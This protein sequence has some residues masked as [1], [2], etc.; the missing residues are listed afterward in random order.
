[1]KL[2]LNGALTIGTLDGANIEIRD[3]VGADN[4]FLF[5]LTAEEVHERQRCGA[6]SRSCVANDP[7]LQEALQMINEG[8]F[9]PEEHGLFRPLFGPMPEHD[10]YMVLADFRAYADCQD[11]V[12]CLWAD[13]S[14]WRRLSILNTARMGYFSSDRAILEYCRDIWRVKPMPIQPR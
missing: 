9:S 1:M 5:G 12:A 7:D 8:F 3:A 6:D 4:F 2:S 10:P 14:G 13:P 11:R